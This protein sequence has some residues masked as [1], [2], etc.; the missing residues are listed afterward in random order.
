MIPPIF[1]T[2][3]DWTDSLLIGLLTF[4]IRGTVL[5]LAAWIATRLLRRAS[6]AT[7]H[8]VWTSA[9][10]GVLLL[11]LLTVLVPA[12]DVPVV[13][14]AAKT[15]AP[16]ESPAAVPAPQPKQSIGVAAATLTGASGA[17]SPTHVAPTAQPAPPGPPAPTNAASFVRRTLNNVVETVTPRISLQGLVAGAWLVLA[18][19][20]LSRLAIA[21]ARVS[22][23]QRSSLAVEDDRWLALLRRLSRQYGIE[24]PVV[25]LENPETDV[26]VTWGIVYPVILLP[27]TAQQWD[28]EQRVA[29]LTHELAHVK[30]FDALTQLLAQLALALLWFHPLVWMAVRRMRLEREHACDDFVLV[31]GAR[32]SR[33]ADDLL[34]FA[35]R[36]TR[37]TAPAAA[38]LAMARRSE[39][40][41]RLLAILDPATKRST[42]RRARVGL[43]TLAVFALATPLAAFRPSV[44]VHVDPKPRQETVVAD[45]Q[46]KTAVPSDTPGGWAPGVQRE[47][48]GS[49][50]AALPSESH[51][52]ETL[53]GRLGAMAPS[54]LQMRASIPVLLRVPGDTEP[55]K[56]VDLETLIDVTKAAKRMTSDIEKGQ[57]L[58]LIAKRY[59]RS[60]ALRDAYL[61]AVFTMT[62]D[63]ERSKALIALLDKDSLPL[64]AVAKV[65]RSTAMMTSDINKGTVL[66]RISPDVF[67]DTAVQR[68]YLDAIVAM[69]SDIERGSAISTLLKQR[70]LAP[71]VQLALLQAIVPITSNVE[72]SNA[73]LLF[74]DRQGIADEKVRRLF[75]KT[76]EGLTSDLEYRRVMTAVMK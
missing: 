40:E 49:K 76:A 58:A 45:S 66:K 38:A 46:T 39:L 29:V 16:L 55:P 42:V 72:K 71:T 63:H 64:S 30:R 32:A 21:T 70:S 65:L 36:L 47:D 20:L 4:A 57:L 14:I 44:R 61:D 7:R 27:A 48:T 6:A 56:Y 51:T 37:P 15:D 75:F 34:G 12:W 8:L 50:V 3:A 11:P 28:E 59:Q 31:A 9:I 22:S 43:L 33:Y 60:D 23:W 26:P 2:T 52:L 35:R 68:A 67:A 1:G 24:R 54:T 41:G 17:S 18:L 62:S 69:T 13:T 5:L 74:L 53:T 73:L 25:L 10:A 19:L